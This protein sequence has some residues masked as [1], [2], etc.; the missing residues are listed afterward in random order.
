MKRT[1]LLL[2]ACCALSAAVAPAAIVTARNDYFVYPPAHAAFHGT[3]SSP[4]I[5]SEW[6]PYGTYTGGTG[7]VECLRLSAKLSGVVYSM[8][9]GLLERA[10]AAAPGYGGLTWDWESDT[11]KFAFA[12][13]VSLWGQW[14]PDDGG[15][16]ESTTN[17]TLRVMDILNL[18]SLGKYSNQGA[19]WRKEYLSTPPDSNSLSL[20]ERL[21]CGQNNYSYYDGDS[22]QTFDGK[23]AHGGL[24]SLFGGSALDDMVGAANPPISSSW[25]T[26]LPFIASDAGK[27]AKVWPTFS[28]LDCDSHF[29]PYVNYDMAEYTSDNIFVRRHLYDWMRACDNENWSASAEKGD[30]FRPQ[31]YALKRTLLTMPLNKRLEDILSK[32]S[33]FEFRGS[34]Y[35]EWLIGGE[36]LEGD[37]S[38]DGGDYAAGTPPTSA[39]WYGDPYNLRW[40]QFGFG[41]VLWRWNWETFDEEIVAVDSSPWGATSLSF[42]GKGVFV[43]HDDYSH[44]RNNTSRLDWKRL[45]IIAQLERHMEES[46][47]PKGELGGLRLEQVV[48]KR[49]DVYQLTND[50]SVSV[51]WSGGSEGGWVMGYSGVPAQEAVSYSVQTNLLSTNSNPYCCVG[52]SL[53]STAWTAHGELPLII[54]M[55]EWNSE[56]EDNP[57]TGLSIKVSLVSHDRSGGFVVEVPGYQWSYVFGPDES[58]SSGVALKT[59]T[60]D[61][62]NSK[63]GGYVH[64]TADFDRS[65]ESLFPAEKAWKDGLVQSVWLPTLECMLS[66]SNDSNF[67]Y[68]GSCTAAYDTMLDHRRQTNA[69]SRVFRMS[70]SSTEECQSTND[71]WRTMRDMLGSLNAEVHATCQSLSGVQL[72]QFVEAANWIPSESEL[73]QARSGLSYECG[74]SVVPLLAE[75]LHEVK[76]S[77]QFVLSDGTVTNRL[78]VAENRSGVQG[79]LVGYVRA[80]GGDVASVRT[81]NSVPVT[82]EGR[83]N[84]MVKTLWRFNNLTSPQQ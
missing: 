83:R 56:I 37:G 31:M 55:S 15:F 41:W 34:E 11:N 62:T 75:G 8:Y 69:M 65:A 40:E 28:A 27:W 20:E 67:A 63:K 47:V 72:S 6:I 46:Y 1:S 32:D 19:G 48:C 78:P 61:V 23:V 73:A 66:I 58:S 39:N 80:T 44:W 5:T 42:G 14:G 35:S 57:S 9:D 82:V 25:T 26:N 33:G 2:S 54:P 7:G 36:L 16:L 10:C 22:E 4:G 79:Y 13:P 30:D 12:V 70:P 68:G 18:H 51:Y 50:Y 81:T 53:V 21:A 38:P 24:A 60:L 74:L 84:T 17:Q 59:C 71:Y 77:P 64:T 52:E 3:P 49:E 76:P 43:T 45:G 29:W